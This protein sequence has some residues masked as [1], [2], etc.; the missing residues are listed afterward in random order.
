[1]ATKGKR[2]IFLDRAAGG[3]IGSRSNGVPFEETARVKSRLRRNL[4]RREKK[5]VP[6]LTSLQRLPTLFRIGY[7]IIASESEPRRSRPAEEVHTVVCA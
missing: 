3:Q 4:R 7:R 1:M 2:F 5:F 6:D